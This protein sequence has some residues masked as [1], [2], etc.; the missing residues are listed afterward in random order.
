MRSEEVLYIALS[1]VNGW[2]LSLKLGVGSG[3]LLYSASS[4][5]MRGIMPSY[6]SGIHNL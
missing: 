2:K 3:M 6:I 1:E 5:V 4:E